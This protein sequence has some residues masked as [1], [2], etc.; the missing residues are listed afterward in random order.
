MPGD[1]RGRGRSC[2]TREGRGC[3]RGQ[4]LP[5]QETYL[6]KST[7]SRVTNLKGAN[8][9]IEFNTQLE[10]LLALYSYFDTQRSF[11]SS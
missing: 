6:R 3:A 11:W 10:V 9:K 8:L 4:V 1:G 7:S 5:D 2:E